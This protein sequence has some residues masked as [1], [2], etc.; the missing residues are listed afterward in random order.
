MSS[1]Q[2]IKIPARIKVCAGD[3]R[4]LIE[5]FKRSLNAPD[6]VD[7][8]ITFEQQAQV[9]AGIVVMKGSLNVNNTNIDDFPTHKFYIRSIADINSSWIIKYAGEFYR[10]LHDGV[11][12]M[13]NRNFFVELNCVR[14][15]T[16][17]R[18][19]NFV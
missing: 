7:A 10:I 16:S 11:S 4:F 6:D 8:I 18:E 12:L 2:R 1:C 15:G 17:D 3:L 19:V 5:L 13:D 9:K 14:R